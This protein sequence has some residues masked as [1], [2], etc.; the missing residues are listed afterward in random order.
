MKRYFNIAGPCNA[1]EHYML[2]ATDRCADLTSLVEEKQYFVIHAA[3]QTGKTTLMMGLVDELNDSGDFYALYCSLETVQGIIEPEKGIPA[4]VR[5]IAH[6]AEWWPID[7]LPEFPKDADLSDFSNVLNLTL[8]QFC[9][10][11]DKPLVLL[12]D[13]VDCLSNGTLITFLRQLRDGYVSRSRIP[14]VHS[15]ALVGM[16]NIRDYKGKIREDRETLG[17]ASP[18][19]IITKALT[20][21]NFT[22]DEV[23]RLYRQHTEATGQ[24]LSDDVVARVFHYTEGQ[25]WLVNAIAREIVVEM[26][27]RDFSR[28]PETEHVDQAVQNIIVR[29]DTHIDSLL[30]R[31]REDRVRSIVE[32][33]IVGREDFAG[34]RLDD[35]EYVR[36]LGLLRD[37]RGTIEP[38]NPIY[39]EV[40]VRWLNYDAQENLKFDRYPYEL[41]RYLNDERQIDMSS[42]LGEFQQFWRENSE[43]WEQR[44]DYREAAP[45]LILMA[46]LQRVLNAGGYIHREYSAGRGRM[47]LCVEFQGRRYPI[48]IKIRYGEKTVEEGQNQLAQ[49]MERMGCGEGWLVVFDRRQDVSWDQRIHWQTSSHDD[50]TIHVVGC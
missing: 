42:L 3:R 39:G 23:G 7:G 2:P 1:E 37:D 4:I 5:R 34:R 44:F 25:P 22:E 24:E 13:E 49:Y 10:K 6:M 43:M 40:I 45:H 17:S 32:P 50:K 28:R 20:L 26:L 35:Y 30:E 19:N 29:R 15:I 38:A 9:A 16:R 36:D 18:F 47:D 33:V 31:L 14:F 11:L 27:E 12:F 21:R 48:E 41:P 8:A 46:F